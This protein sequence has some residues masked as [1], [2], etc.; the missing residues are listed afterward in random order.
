MHRTLSLLSAFF[1]FTSIMLIIVGTVTGNT[2]VSV[3]DRL[4]R[5]GRRMTAS[6]EDLRLPLTERLWRP[7]LR[8]VAAPVARLTP[9]RVSERLRL[10]IQHAGLSGSLDVQN[11]MALRVIAMLGATGLSITLMLLTSFWTAGQSSTYPQS[12]S[13]IAA[14]STAGGPNVLSI[15]AISLGLGGLAY[16]LPTLWIQGQARQRQEAI[17]HAMPDALDL[18][19][20]CL[21]AMPPDRALARVTEH[22]Q[23]PLRDELQRLRSEMLLQAPQDALRAMADRVGVDEVRSLVAAMVQSEQLGTQLAGPLSALAVDMRV[24][25][26]QRAETVA[27]EAPV[28]MI[29]PLVLLILPPLFI[30]ILGPAIPQ[31]LRAIAPGIHL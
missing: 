31:M 11:F 12:T 3:R 28:K 7:L 16:L 26:R 8:G 9:Q 10:A 4:A 29:F 30:V 2:R 17:R 18:L 6:E 19:L 14:G 15:L 13:A 27:R 22:A 1:A 20:L 24:R 25:R 21:E 5:L 23:G